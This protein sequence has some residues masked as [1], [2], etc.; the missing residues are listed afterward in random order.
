MDKWT[1]R[2]LAVQ[3]SNSVQQKDELLRDLIP[4]G[5]QIVRNVWNINI[6]K[7]DEEYRVMLNALMDAIDRCKENKEASFYTFLCLVIK[8]R[9][10]DYYRGQVKEK[11]R[12]A[13]PKEYKQAMID[14]AIEAYRRAEEKENIIHELN[15]LHRKLSQCN[16]DYNDVIKQRPKHADS[17]REVS[18][19]AHKIYESG[20][21]REFI[22]DPTFSKALQRQIGI[23]V[24][25]R[26]VKQY[27]NYII[28]LLWIMK[29]R[30]ELP[31]ISKYIPKPQE[32]KYDCW[33][34]IETVNIKKD[35]G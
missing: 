9:L 25:R 24:Q 18:Y 35:I 5:E 16:I 11:N 17:R 13:T 30:D 12:K 32:I 14:A 20:L 28:A 21:M 19:W 8:S 27:R 2:V 22:V 15:F 33:G 23:R 26:R 1:S 6:D 31:I 7:H 10:I 3:K 4:L 29:Y 34:Y